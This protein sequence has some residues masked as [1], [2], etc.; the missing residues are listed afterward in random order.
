[1]GGKLAMSYFDLLLQLQTDCVDNLNSES[2][3]QYL[4]ALLYRKAVLATEITKRLPHLAGKNGKLGCGLVVCMPTIDGEYPNVT[5]PQGDVLL[6]IWAVEQPELN[7]QSTGTQITAEQA[8]LQ[9]RAWLHQ[10]DLRG[11]IT[12]YQDQRAVEPLPGCEKEYPGCVGYQ[13]IARGKMGDF[14]VSA[15]ADPT[16]TGD[17]AA[18]TLA[19]ASEGASI[20]YTTDG[21]FPGA[22]N[23]TGVATLYTEPFSVNVGTVVAFKAYLAGSRGSNVIQYTINS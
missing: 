12:L 3:F 8:I 10:L 23:S 2:A 6:P 19:C 11:Q 1:M 15:V 20:Y 22:G 4:P 21:S 16:L 13:F 18:L 14:P 9:V 17:A 5:V 7:F